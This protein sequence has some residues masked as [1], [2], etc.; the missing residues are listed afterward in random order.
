[1]EVQSE[2]VKGEEPVDYL[3]ILTFRKDTKKGQ[4][5]AKL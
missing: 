4:E 3:T 2:A 1:M 5:K